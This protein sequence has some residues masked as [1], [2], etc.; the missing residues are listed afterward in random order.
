[1]MFAAVA[2]AQIIADS[3]ETTGSSGLTIKEEVLG[4]KML[5]DMRNQLTGLIPGLEIVETAG[6]L[7]NSSNFENIIVNS[8]QID[9]KNRG[10]GSLSCYIDGMVIPFSAYSLDPS[11]IES[12]SLV[13]NLVQKAQ[14]GPC[15][16]YGTIYIKTKHGGYNQPLTVKVNAE[17]GIATPEL[18]PEWADG[19]D[20][21][22]LNN[23]ARANAGYKQLYSPLAIQGFL[24][25][26]A[27]DLQYPNVD[28]RSLFVKDM[29]PVGNVSMSLSGGGANVKYAASVSE[30]YSGDIM[31]TNEA[32]DYNRINISSNVTSRI[33]DVLEINAGFNSS[34]S[35]RRASS[36]SWNAWQ[37]V[38]SVVYPVIL[39]VNKSDD[40]GDDLAGLTIYGTTPDW[41]N[42]YYAALAEGGFSTRRLRSAQIYANIGVDFSRWIKG[43]RSDTYVGYST[44]MATTVS[45]SN[46]YLSYYWDPAAADGMDKISPTHQGAKAS[47][48]S[49]S[50]TGANQL[51]Q[52]SEKLSWD[53]QWGGHKAHLGGTFLIYEASM[54]G[55]SYYRRTMQT[56]AE[57]RYSYKDK[58]IVEGSA[59]YVGSS[60]YMKDQR[61]KPFGAVGA[62]WIVSNEDFLK[63]CSFID[64]LKIRGQFGLL[65]DFNGVFGTQYLYD[66]DYSFGNGNLYGPTLTL[67]TWF[68][69]KTWRSQKT[70]VNRLANT[71]LTWPWMKSWEAGI[72]FDF[73]KGF[74]FSADVYCYD[75]G[76]SIAD[77]TGAVPSVYGIEGVTVYANYTETRNM[78]YEVRLG[79]EHS[80]GDFSLN[81]AATVYGWEHINTRL[82]SDDYLY[83]YQRKTGRSTYSIWGLECIGKYETQEQVDIIPAYGSAQIGDL[84]YKD[85]NQDG[86][87]DSNDRIVIGSSNPKLRCSL[88]FGFK[89]K[90]LEVQLI[91]TGRYGYDMALTDDYFWSGWGDDNYSAFV[92]D[93]IGGE[94]PRLSYTKSNNNFVAS[95]FWLRSSYWF[96][97]QDAMLAYYVPL[98]NCKSLKGLTFQ[99][100]GQNLAT[101]T[102]VKY[103]E[104]EETAAGISAY[105]LFRSVTAGVKLNF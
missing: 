63:D 21:A 5:G 61:F 11:Q 6:G 79:Y 9:L 47:A 53:R 98:K 3:L 38:P 18:I 20:Y 62:A 105:P 27:Y 44:F 81:A 100:K 17:A 22:L 75:Q 66:S 73:L 24:K 4:K 31:N 104:P 86:L 96:K 40:A 90:N 37:K 59:Q 34:M 42:N 7:W 41:T 71:E 99:L 76:G 88:N 32:Q 12:V 15:A 55:L 50:S 52:M 60:R 83:D 101:F 16:S 87:I 77:V 56:L 39:G 97:L 28:Y 78:G 57:A 10:F 85:Q 1:M 33:N 93:N 14:L 46:D 102:N 2:N 95:D 54:Q 69:N 35:F 84:M 23:Q 29:M 30:Q 25:G 64:K 19:V 70:T 89:Y 58:Y 94:Y 68:G 8:A 103:V 49:I 80:W 48:K 36:L 91:G 65:A 51:L 26:N 13:T 67:E 82:V 74:K 92:R 72:D 45:K 43:L